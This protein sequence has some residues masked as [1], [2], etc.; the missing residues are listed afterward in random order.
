M[1]LT[2]LKIGK[3]DTFVTFMLP[4]GQ[5]NQSLF[6]IIMNELYLASERKTSMRSVE[7]RDSY[8]S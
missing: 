2:V 8:V 3:W 1:I 5:N 6:R 7:D 4:I